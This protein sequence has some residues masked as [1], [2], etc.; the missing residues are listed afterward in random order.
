MVQQ[1]ALFSSIQDESYALAVETLTILS[2]NQPLIFSNLSNV[3]KPNPSLQIEK[4]NAKNQLV[5][6]TRIKLSTDIPLSQLGNGQDLDYHFLERLN[7][8]SIDSFDLD[9]FVKATNENDKNHWALQ[10]SDIPAAGNN[11]KLSNQAIHESV[12]QSSRGPVSSFIDELGYVSDYQF[13]NVGIKFQFLSGIVME[14]YKIWQVV[15][16]GERFSSKLI[17]K[18]GFM[19]KAMY[20]VIKSTD[21]ESINH[22]TRHLLKLKSD[23]RDYIELDLPDR[24]SMDSRLN[25]LD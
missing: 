9:A 7:E 5:E 10:I 13:I 22:G 18:D 14:V 21:I 3:Y 23:L 6:Q 20:N 4:V 11:R 19:M 15:K 17:T 24:K 1:L 12:L 25:H 2:S 8:D 16:D